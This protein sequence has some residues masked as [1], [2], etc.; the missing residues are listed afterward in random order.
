MT[1]TLHNYFR[2]STSFRVRI[3]LNLKGLDYDY[4]GYKLI[5]AEQRGDAYLALN[6][7]GLVPALELPDGRVLTQSLAIIEYL[8]AVYPDPA[9]LPVD[10]FVAATVRAWAYRIACDI[11]P[12]NNLRVLQ[13]L[14]RE[15]GADDA[16]VAAWFRHW[17]AIEFANLE[18]DLA[19]RSEALPFCFGAAPGLADLCLIPQVANG[20]RFDFDMRPY[21]LIQAIYDR[22]MQIPAV[23]KAAPPHQPD[24]F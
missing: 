1:M 7:Q 16:A 11:H 13:Y 2:S 15:F 6:R 14:R 17:A 3:A 4:V 19:A 10:P 23:A 12:I 8:D 9:L 18:A 20:A 21:P 22:A 5:D 24:A